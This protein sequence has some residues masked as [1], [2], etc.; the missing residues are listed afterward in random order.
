MFWNAFDMKEDTRMNNI[1]IQCTA[2]DMLAVRFKNKCVYI[3]D[4]RK[5]S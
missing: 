2:L 1:C 5:E 4:I 3:H